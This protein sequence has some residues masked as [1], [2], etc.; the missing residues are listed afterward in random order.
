MS[1]LL[2]TFALFSNPILKST[3]NFLQE[4]DKRTSD[5]YIPLNIF[6]ISPLKLG[7]NG[8]VRMYQ[9]VSPVERVFIDIVKTVI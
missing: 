6:V 4:K 3:G 2:S 7:L 9:A 1:S 5:N 8:S